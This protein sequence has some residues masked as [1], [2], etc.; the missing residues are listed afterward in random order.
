MPVCSVCEGKAS[1]Q[2]N[3]SWYCRDCMQAVLNGASPLAPPRKVSLMDEKGNLLRLPFCSICHN[4][5]AMVVIGG[6]VKCRDCFRAKRA[7]ADLPEES[8]AVPD[9]PKRPYLGSNIV[10]FPDEYMC[11]DVETT[12]RS[13]AEDEIIEVAAVHVK[14]GAVCNTFSSLVRP[15][16]SH[17]PWTYEEI[18][19]LGYDSYDDVPRAVFEDDSRRKLIP[20][21]IANLTKIS[22]DMVRD[23]PGAD[24]VMPK[25]FA[26][27]GKHILV[28]H[29]ALF[30]MNFLYDACLRCGCILENDYVDTLRIARNLLPQLESHSLASLVQYFEIVQDHAHRAEADARATVK[31]LEAMKTMVLQEQTIAE[32]EKGLWIPTGGIFRRA[33]SRL[34]PGSISVPRILCSRTQWIHPIHCAERRLSLPVSSAWTGLTP[35]KWRWIRAQLSRQTSPGRRI[36]W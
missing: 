20:G 23:A 14:G 9:T 18:H 13:P 16:C 28:G 10:D 4:R 1:Y 19:E 29:N 6:S 34:M 30:D 15:S 7:W 35:H 12:G 11:V 2:L 22:D 32:Y 33:E 26:F 24:E 31:C 36:S 21:E 5:I 8:E 25:F 27:V 3:G 17:V